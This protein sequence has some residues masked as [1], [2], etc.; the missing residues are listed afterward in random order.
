MGTSNWQQIPFC[1]DVLMKIAPSR[2]LDIGVGFGRWGI[3]LREF[4]E[5]WSGRIFREQWK[6]QVEGIEGFPRNINDYHGSFYNKIHFGDAAELLPA[7]AGPWSVVIFGDVLEHFTKEKASELLR[8]SLDRSDYVMINVPI[9]DQW[10]Q[11]DAYGNKY[12]R[13][14]SQWVPDDFKEFS[15]VREQM[16]RDPWGRP[17]GTFVLSRVDPSNLRLGVYS[18]VNAYS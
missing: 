16:F 13:H 5:V 10:P 8:I 2:V 14:L 1:I 12:E 3:I 6:I 15:L 4:C 18:P 17:H 11:E 9:G 7:I